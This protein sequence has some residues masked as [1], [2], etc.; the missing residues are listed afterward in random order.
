MPL[1]EIFHRQFWWQRLREMWEVI[2]EAWVACN[3]DEV[4]G[5]SAQL[6]FYFMLALFPALLGVKALV[7]MLPE[8]VLLPTLMFYAEKVLPEES[9]ILV[10]RYVDQVIQGGGDRVFYLSLL[11]S[12][13]AASWGMMAII[14]SLNVVYGVQET[15]PLWKVGAI[16]VLLTLGA[17]IF[18]ITSLILILAGEQ[19]IRWLGDF[20]NKEEVGVTFY[21]SL[22]QWPII[23]LIMLV[24]LNLI[25]YFAPNTDHEWQWIKPGSILAVCLWVILSLGLKYYVETFVDYNPV[26]GSITG[27]IILM[28]WLYVSGF[29]LLLGGELNYTLKK[30]Q[31]RKAQQE[32]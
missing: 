24:A 8:Q 12:L 22:L 29:A 16:S 13:W 1:Q 21:W 28:M 14:N 20:V 19:V 7:G 11:G 26:Y 9:L 27:V 5:R 23:V 6:G 3:K 2:E 4:L 18:V 25:Y 30:R 32:Q 17:A 10:E 15:R 31:R